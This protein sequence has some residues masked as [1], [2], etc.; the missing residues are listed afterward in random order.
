LALSGPFL[1]SCA[2]REKLFIGPQVR[3]LRLKHGLRLESCAVKLGIS[4]S[5]LSQIEANQRPVT[6]RVLD[7]LA[8]V[9][10][11]G[12]ETFDVRQSDRLAADLREAIAES[13]T[14]GSH[15]PLSEVRQAIQQTPSLAR[16]FL[17]LHRANQRL[18]ERLSLTEQAV[19]LDEATAASSLLPYEEVREFFHDKDNYVD[20]LD[21]AAEALAMELGLTAGGDVTRR[22][23]M[24]LADHLGVQVHRDAEG[25][26]MRRF[27]PDLGK[28][29]INPGQPAATQAFQLAF[30]L[31][32]VELGAGIEAEL[33]QAQFRTPEAVD[34]CRVGLRNYA[35]G[36]LLMPYGRFQ[37]AAAAQR[38]DIEALALVFQTS[39][40]QVCHRL[41]TLQRPGLR[42]VPLFFVRM[43][44]AGNITKR[45]SATRLRFARFGGACPLWNV[46]EAVG[47]ADRFL[48]Q[49]VEMPDA[50]RYLSVA[51]RITKPSG[52]YHAPDRNYVL[53]FG[54]DV[55][56]AGELVYSDGID[57]EGPAARIG[58]SCRIC[59]RDD[60][61]QRAFPPVD[62]PLRVP[63]HERRPVPFLTD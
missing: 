11:V 29:S 25:D 1:Q 63:A 22:L 47:A 56:R 38:H 45:H 17:E 6:A 36:A 58:I 62:R 35:A 16:C 30:H 9:F 41:S 2:V 19:A 53:G 18:A 50:T 24:R 15:V 32:E 31:V 51:R 42:G 14:P 60:C 23:E 37:A 13:G 57:L 10:E 61:T 48:V 34:V 5:Y 40:E 54:C 28:L 44:Y 27:R 7:K 43:D 46:H 55:S 59:E 33:A 52:R 39:L 26:V 21:R 49:L 3:A 20:S 12:L 8:E 4:G